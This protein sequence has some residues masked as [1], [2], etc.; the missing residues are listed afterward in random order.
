MV[1]HRPVELAA[2]IRSWKRHF[3]QF[4]SKGFSRVADA[5]SGRTSM[6]PSNSLPAA[7]YLRMSTERQQYSLENQSTAIQAYASLHAFEIVQ[8][9]TD[10]A[11]S[12][13]SLKNRTGLQQ[14]LRD[15]V[16]GTHAF[17]AILVYDV[18]RWG[19][20]QDTDEPAHY[21]FLCKSAGVP[22][23]YCAETFANDGTLPSLIMKALKRTM[24]GEYSRELGVKVLAGQKR[25][26]HLGF[27]QGGPPGYGLRRM[28][29]N[30]DRMPKQI[31]E[32]GERKSIATDR[33]T[34]VPGPP[35]EVQCVR[36]I[37]R[38]LISEKRTV[39]GIA[40]ELNRRG[41]EYVGHAS[42]DYQAVYHILT[43][44]KYVGCHVFNQ[45]SR[46]LY[47]P[48]IRLPKSDWVVTPNAFEPIVA[49]AT[50][51][52]AQQVI[53]SRTF[54]KS[55]DQILSDLKR[56]LRSKG[57]LS[58]SLIRDCAYLPSPSTF[59]NRFGNLRQAYA[60][61]GYGRPEQFG[62]LDKR[63]KTRVL[64]EELFSQ[65]IEAAPNRL[66]IVQRTARWRMRLQLHGG[67]TVS[68]IVARPNP[69][70]KRTIRWMIVPN[71]HEANFI[72]L[73]ARLDKGHTAFMDFYVFA[74]IGRKDRFRISLHDPWLNAGVK[75]KDLSRLSD[76]ATSLYRGR[77]L[78]ARPTKEIAR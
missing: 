36:E 68:V 77:T 44:P 19:R 63:Q 9:Y 48:A 22:V 46:K 14:L 27:K 60:R 35:A 1:L 3:I 53:Q 58:L 8:T 11:R 78:P 59:R 70:W 42:W 23:H 28:L 15:V 25:L 7:Q 17:Q 16:S 6:K 45:T 34:L 12:G 52:K 71:R 65:I 67:P 51:E 38:M 57:R 4:S 74:R 50:F 37:F 32:T 64:R 2:S 49:L 41:I 54:N 69:V 76:T 56:L 73:V 24:A 75:L 18:S 47:T 31:L 55:N 40:R 39:Y 20:F 21:E 62:S 10:N 26:A 29:V 66:V 30:P 13:V 5:A 33:V 72:T 61:V 43:H